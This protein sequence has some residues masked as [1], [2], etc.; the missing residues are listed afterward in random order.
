M[1]SPAP[2]FVSG[3]SGRKTDRC[4]KSGREK[5]GLLREHL[6]SCWPQSGGDETWERVVSTG[7]WEETLL[8]HQNQRVVSGVG[9]SRARVAGW[10]RGQTEQMPCTKAR[11]QER[12]WYGHKKKKYIP[13]CGWTLNTG[14]SV[15]EG[16]HKRPRT[17]TLF[18]WKFCEN[19]K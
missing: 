19:R 7:L 12:T 17:V 2:R 18:N 10:G 11:Q 16:R 8:V 9:E 14:C 15:K 1:S 5:F 6:G 3:K 13:Q 4:L